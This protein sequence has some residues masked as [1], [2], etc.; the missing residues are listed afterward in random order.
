LNTSLAILSVGL[1]HQGAKYATS[2]FEY[3]LGDLVGQ[4]KPQGAK[5]VRSFFEYKFGDLGVL[6]VRII[7][8][9]F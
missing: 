2:F 1:N 3:K 9:L 5:Y 7:A 6:A 8:R 4:I